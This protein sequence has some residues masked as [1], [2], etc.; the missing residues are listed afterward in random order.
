MARIGIVNNPRARRNRRHPETAQALRR[1]LGRDGLVRD[2]ATDE[3]AVAALAEFRRE[4]VGLLGVNGGDGTLSRIATALPAGWGDPPWPPLAPLPAGS[5]NNVARAHGH[6]GGPERTLRRILRHRGEGLPL[7]VVERDLLRVVAPGHP[8]RLGFLFATGAAVR[9]L[10]RWG[11]TEGAGPL[12]AAWLLARA[13][14]S[15]LAGGRLAAEIARREALRVVAD[16]DEW[17]S[18]EW[19]AVL[20]GSVPGVGLGS[21]PFSRCD[22]QPGFFH[23][24]GVTASPRRLVLAM[25]ALWRGRP[26]R[27]QVALDAVARDLLLEPRQA[28]RFTLDGDVFDSAGPLRVE[29]GPVVEV[30]ADPTRTP[31][32]SPRPAD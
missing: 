9:F 6:R 18:T 23:A 16:G 3:E 21:R 17:P 2:V 25:P 7:P 11:G 15:A 29:S 32:P 8:N 27:R 22:E 31:P 10:E 30:V 26:W 5:M 14:A 19:L 12:R 20:A 13:L 4:G 24:V 28:L 1:L